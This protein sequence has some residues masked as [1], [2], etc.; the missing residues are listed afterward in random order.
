MATTTLYAPTTVSESAALLALAKKVGGVENIVSFENEGKRYA[1]VVK[2]A[3][4]DEGEE[5]ESSD[6]DDGGDDKPAF[7]KGDEEKSESEGDSDD[8]SK[9]DSG[10]SDDGEDSLGDDDGDKPPFAE[11]GDEGKPTLEGVFDLVKQIAEAVGVPTGGPEDGLGL[12]G[13]SLGGDPLGGDPSVAP[14]L[15]LTCRT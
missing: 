9:D 11:D 10:D 15:A 5:S 8:D 2:V 14:R 1:A 12:P 3:D 4:H 13:E 6:S 7:L